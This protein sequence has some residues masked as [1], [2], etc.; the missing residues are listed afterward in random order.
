MSKSEHHTPASASHGSR[1][2]REPRSVLHDSCG[3]T[4][5]VEGVDLRR[6]CDPYVESVGPKCEACGEEF[7]FREFTWED[8]SESLEDFRRRMQ[9]LI[10]ES[11]NRIH[12]RSAT[13]IFLLS[14]VLSIACLWFI[15]GILWKVLSVPVVVIG[16]WTLGSMTIDFVLHRVMGSV[17]PQKEIH[18]FSEKAALARLVPARYV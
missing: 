11:H 2:G 7:P 13:F 5:V 3:S 4:S 15:P 1:P 8:T 17:D 9:I 12:E 18:S 16:T 14:I 6:V 10:P